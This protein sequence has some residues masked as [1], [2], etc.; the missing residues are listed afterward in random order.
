MKT[1]TA[2]F[3]LALCATAIAPAQAQ[4]KYPP[5]HEF[6]YKPYQGEN[7]FI[8][9]EIKDAVAVTDFLKFRIKFTNKT[10]DYIFVEPQKM[11]LVIN[12]QTLNF[13]EKGFFLRPYENESKT[14]DLGR[15][16]DFHQETWSLDFAN[17]FTVAKSTGTTIEMD[18]FQVPPTTNVL[19][20]KLLT[21]NMKSIVNKTTDY[22]NVRFVSKYT[23]NKI[24]I[25]DPSRTAVKT[26]AGQQ[27]ANAFAKS[28]PVLL[29]PGEED[30]FNVAAKIPIQVVDMQFA[31]LFVV[32]GEAFQ[33][34]DAKPFT[35]ETLNFTID[36]ARTKM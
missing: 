19:Q 33:E 35:F 15:T 7:E 5:K 25:V 2:L 32:W 29:K 12:G 36:P 27:Y 10:N 3:A 4:K 28:K 18:D 34:V 1:L 26:E 13:R 23:G 30:S 21:V 16:M 11:K 31:N 17:G 8:S 20:N 14:L 9:I 6:F 22:F 24:L